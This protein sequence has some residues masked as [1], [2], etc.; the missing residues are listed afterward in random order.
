MNEHK[1]ILFQYIQEKHIFTLSVFTGSRVHS[2]P[3]FYDFDREEVGLIFM[4]EEKTIH[5]RA[6]LLHPEC[7]G[8]IYDDVR[9]VE[10]IRGLQMHGVAERL[11]VSPEDKKIKN[12]LKKFPEAQK[13]S[14]HFYNFKISWMKFTDNSVD[15]G[16][17]REWGNDPFS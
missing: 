17:K 8:A 4:S 12:Y 13:H 5:V 14:G 6:L 16:F 7:S 3:L 10:K 2:A 1:E 11:R 15:F 9:Q